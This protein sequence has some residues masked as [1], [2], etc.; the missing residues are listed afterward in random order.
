MNDTE[1][2]QKNLPRALLALRLGVFLV[3]LMWTLDKFVNPGH[4]SGIMSRFYNIQG[5][6]STIILLM[7][8]LE[9]LLLLAFVGGLY[10]RWTYGAVFLLHASS[11]LISWRFYLG[12]G[13]LTFFAAWPMLAACYTLYILRHE[14]VLLTVKGHRMS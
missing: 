2:L 3:M 8:G 1:N 5:L 9:L 4:A 13:N 11:T 6:E 10:K 14:D 12:F 7:G